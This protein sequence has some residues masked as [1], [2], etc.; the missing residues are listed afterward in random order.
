MDIID[1][2]GIKYKSNQTRFVR[3]LLLQ[4]VSPKV[5]LQELAL[6]ELLKLAQEVLLQELALIELLQK[7]SQENISQEKA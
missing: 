6:I 7:L 3:T 2:I 5:L 1:E 4:K